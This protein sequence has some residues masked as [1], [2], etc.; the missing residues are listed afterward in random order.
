MSDHVDEEL[1]ERAQD[2]AL[3]DVDDLDLLPEEVTDRD[4]PEFE[5]VVRRMAAFDAEMRHYQGL[6]DAAKDRLYRERDRIREIMPFGDRAEAADHVVWR[7]EFP[8]VERFSIRAMREA[9]ETLPKRLLP[10]VRESEPGE[11]W[12]I[13]EAKVRESKTRV[14]H[15]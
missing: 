8:A 10:F 6:A 14:R 3:F 15:A 1:L 12:Y 5:A 11:R 7:T 9:G 4:G 2:T 13:R